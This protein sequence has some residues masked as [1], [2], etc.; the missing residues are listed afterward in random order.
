[1]SSQ[2]IWSYFLHRQCPWKYP[3][4]TVGVEE[5]ETDLKYLSESMVISSAKQVRIFEHWRGV[6]SPIVIGAQML[7]F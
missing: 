3:Q 6:F 5:V 7:E 4:K 1:M 2:K